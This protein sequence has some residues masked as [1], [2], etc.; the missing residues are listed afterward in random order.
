[1][2]CVRVCAS[3]YHK[4]LLGTFCMWLFYIFAYVDSPGL[5]YQILKN[6][7]ILSTGDA[8]LCYD[9][10]LYVKDL[11]LIAL[12]GIIPLNDVVV[13]DVDSSVDEDGLFPIFQEKEDVIARHT[14]LTLL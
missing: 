7:N 5:R 10:G 14:I 9:Y 4:I 6:L 2:V 1:M 3:D 8:S 13:E 11:C 12:R